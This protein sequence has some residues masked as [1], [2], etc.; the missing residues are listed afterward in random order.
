MNIAD[1]ELVASRYYRRDVMAGYDPALDV[2][3][4]APD[5]DIDL[6]DLQ[7]V[8]GRSGST[9]VAPLPPQPPPA[10]ASIADTD[11]DGVPDLVDACPSVADPAQPNSDA[12]IDN[13]PA[14]ARLDRTVP[15]SDGAGDACDADADNDGLLNVEDTEPLGATGV[16]AAFAGA[17]D[18]HAFPAAGDVTD[19]DHTGPSWDTDGDGALD[20]VE[21]Q[22]GTNP[23]SA[24]SKPAVAQCGG[25]TDADHD[26]LTA[27]AERCKWGTADTAA[28]S[29]GDG[30]KDCVEAND[31]NGDGVAELPRRHPRLRARGLEP[32]AEDA[33]L[34]SQRRRIHLLPRRYHPLREDG[35]ARRRHLSVIAHGSASSTDRASAP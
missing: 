14:Y 9:C 30:L 4:A 7:F 13:G 12:L 2:D 18:A 35:L 8:F 5:G 32:H 1:E 29:D 34:R 10:V 25:A 21:C 27:A 33:R 20:G 23:R 6:N 24:A 17:S 16:C 28:D 26:G 31:T 15:D 3:P 22:L 19:A 11:G